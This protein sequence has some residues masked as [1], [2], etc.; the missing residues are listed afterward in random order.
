[1]KVT[2]G[3][4]DDN[5][6]FVKSLGA[7]I[8]T[9]PQFEVIVDA[10][11]GAELLRKME[12]ANIRPELLLLDVSMPSMD[13][14]TTAQFITEKYPLIKMAALSQKDDDNTIIR[15]IRAGCC[16]YLL[17]DIHAEELERAL[18][19]IHQKGYYNGDYYNVNHRRLTDF[20]EK[21]TAPP[22]N[23]R[24]RRFLQLCCSDLTYKQIAAQMHL[25][26][27]TIDGYRES[28]FEKFKVQSRTG[29]VLE[30]VKKQLVELS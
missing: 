4:A 9:F 3:V 6:L 21:K 1:M 16:A 28:I 19:E 2:V 18:V 10:L 12:S 17:K 11:N 22:I 30:A 15:M 24:E 26:E 14:I 8:N 23:D 7:L 13:G 27:R 5:H 20:E 25:S 29:M